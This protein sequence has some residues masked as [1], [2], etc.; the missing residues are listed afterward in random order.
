[1]SSPTPNKNIYQNWRPFFV[2]LCLYFIAWSILPAFISSSVP[3]DVSEGISWGSEWQWG[4]YKHPPLSSWILYSFY[5]LFG[6][7]GPYLLS[8]LYVLLTLYLVYQLG[9]KVWSQETALLGSALTLAVLYYTYPSLEF[10]HNVAQFPIWAG[11]YLAFYQSL[12]KNRLRDWILLGV[13]GGLGMLTKYTVIFLLIPM[14]LYLVLPKQWPLL[15]Q[16]KPWIAAF[17]MLAIFSPHL[18][19]LITHDWLPLS[20]A[21]GRSHEVD[22]GVYSIKRHFSWIGFITAQLVAHILLIVMFIF[23]RKR[24]VSIKEYKHNLSDNASLLWYMWLSP[25]AVLIVLSLVFGVGLRDMWGM[26]MWA[27]SGLLAASFIAPA[28]KLLT[29]IKLRKA[30]IIWLSIVTALMIVYVGFGD[31]I[32]HKP[33]RMQWPEQALAIQS[34]NTW[35]VLSSCSLDSVSGDRW[36]GSLVAMNSGFPSQMISGL[37]SH[38]PWMT[39]ERLQENGTLVI[40]QEGKE[41]IVLPLLNKVN[42]ITAD[43]LSSNDSNDNILVKQQGQWQVDWRDDKVEKPLLINWMAYVPSRCFRHSK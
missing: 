12:T 36:L 30:L 13:F 5:Q 8:Q 3:L 17:V 11:L 37:A 34:Q 14:A 1:M 32:R 20:Y 39:I 41:D 9:K 2:F 23:N 40:W 28:T 10:N 35:Q 26:P 4:Y 38:S 33:S 25:I 18:Y 22:D 31:K 19:W 16:P 7:V 42:V 6:H 27:L 15:K 29:T 21:N 43:E 24:L